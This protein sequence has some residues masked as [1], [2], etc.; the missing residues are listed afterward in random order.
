MQTF[1][2][3]CGGRV[4]GL[5][6]SGRKRA[7]RGAFRQVDGLEERCLLSP[8]DGSWNWHP[9]TPITPAPSD[10]GPYNLT[11]NPNGL[12]QIEAPDFGGIALKLKIKGDHIKG[13]GN[14]GGAKVKVD[15]TGGTSDN[16]TPND[17]G[18]LNGDVTWKGKIIDFLK[19]VQMAIQAQHAGP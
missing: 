7:V 17:P 5:S 15:L 14:S 10:P 4:L 1:L 8:F 9:V 13:K 11:I 19:N 6:L 12:S 2:R 18:D 16:R 3:R